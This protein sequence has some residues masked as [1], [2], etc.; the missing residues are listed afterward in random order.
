MSAP[1]RC[2][3]CEYSQF[4]SEEKTLC[5]RYPPIYRNDGCYRFPEVEEYG[6]CGEYKFYQPEE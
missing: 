6:W 3:V 2:E 1:K 4:I 5:R